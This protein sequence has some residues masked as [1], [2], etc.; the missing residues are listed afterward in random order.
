[1][2]ARVY[3]QSELEVRGVKVDTSSELGSDKGYSRTVAAQVQPCQTVKVGHGIEAD[4][5][6][7]FSPFDAVWECWV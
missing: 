3:V 7:G 2:V 4:M 1:M 6:E 5:R